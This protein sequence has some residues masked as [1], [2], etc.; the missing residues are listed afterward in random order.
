MEGDL[1]DHRHD[2]AEVVVDPQRSDRAQTG[3]GDDH[4]APNGRGGVVV[5]DVGGGE[6]QPD[7][8]GSPTNADDRGP[9]RGEPV[10]PVRQV[11]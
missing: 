1:R 10:A 6:H 2:A 5:V 7:A 3:V 8:D 4:E 9:E 11:D